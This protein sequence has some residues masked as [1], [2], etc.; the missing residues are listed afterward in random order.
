MSAPVS[1]NT[2]TLLH[3]SQHAQ[4]I[5]LDSFIKGLNTEIKAT[6]LVKDPLNLQDAY[7]LAR[8]FEDKLKSSPLSETEKLTET[9]KNLLK[10][11]EKSSSSE[12]FNRPAIRRTQVVKCQYCGKSGHGAKTCFDLKKPALTGNKNKKFCQLCSKPG[13]EAPQCYSLRD[14]DGSSKSNYKKKSNND[15]NNS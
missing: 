3:I 8:H 6:V 7:K 10:G 11:A 15:N 9:L 5:A 1:I 14:D 13:H 2:F 12:S 4:K